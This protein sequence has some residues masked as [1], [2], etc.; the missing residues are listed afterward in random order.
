MWMQFLITAGGS[1]AGL[2][3]AMLVMG[4]FARKHKTFTRSVDE[5]SGR[6]NSELELIASNWNEHGCDR[7]AAKWI[8][9]W[10]RKWEQQR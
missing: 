10:N 6:P 9:D 1:F 4:S 3:S 8:L 5:L 2:C 7:I